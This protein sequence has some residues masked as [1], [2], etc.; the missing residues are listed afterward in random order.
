LKDYY[1]VLGVLRTASDAEIKRAFR[2]LAITYHPDKNKSPD[3]QHIFVEINEA[4][5]T[6]GDP[7]KRSVYDSRLAN[8]LSDLIVDPPAQQRHRDP[9]YRRPRKAGPIVKEPPLTAHYLKYIHWCCWVGF[10]LSSLFF[11][12]YVLPYETIDNDSVVSVKVTRGRRGGVAYVTSTTASGSRIKHYPVE[13]ACVLY[14]G[15]DVKW[16]RTLIFRTPIRAT[17]L[18]GSVVER[19]GH[20]YGA[21]LF[22]PVGVFITA[23]AGI[24]FKKRSDLAFNM[25]LVCIVLMIFTYVFL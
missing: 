10:T 17:S 9:A 13:A 5:E 7:Q 6:I 19:L 22:F 23:A 24:I 4:Y 15:A 8:P 21:L 25:S 16:E 18:D 12:D 1:S 3:A 2:K 20:L 14:E 11:I